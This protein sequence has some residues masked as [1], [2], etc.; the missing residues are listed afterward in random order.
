MFLFCCLGA[1]F[2]EW[3][4]RLNTTTTTTTE[5]S[6]RWPIHAPA[7]FF[8]KS[9]G[10]KFFSIIL[11]E[12]AKTFR[13]LNVSKIWL[14]QKRY[15]EIWYFFFKEKLKKTKASLFFT[16]K[17]KKKCLVNGG[18]KLFCWQK[19]W[20]CRSWIKRSIDRSRTNK[21]FSDYFT[22]NLLDLK[23]L[24]LCFWLLPSVSA[25]IYSINASRQL[26]LCHIFF[27]FFFRYHLHGLNNTNFYKNGSAWPA[28]ATS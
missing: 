18:Q 16:W 28:S 19:D 5:T 27:L 6:G 17:L 24:I 4:C 9:I 23:T 3:R 7:S 13:K 21:M 25:T 1:W 8:L 14:F 20:Q 11:P 2:N 10:T 22:L 12:G 15:K 26:F